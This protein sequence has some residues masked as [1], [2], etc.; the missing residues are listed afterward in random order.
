MSASPF[1][2]RRLG[3]EEVRRVLQ[4]ALELA[5]RDGGGGSLSEAE[6]A[7]RLTELG[8]PPEAVRLAMS[9][10]E[11]ERGD[12][13]GGVDGERYLAERELP[14]E[15]PPQRDADV[16]RALAGAMTEPGRVHTS[17]R[18]LTWKPLDDA[19]DLRVSVH[20]G[21]GRTRVRIEQS[22]RHRW[23]RPLGN[24]AVIAGF[25][26]LLAM[27]VAGWMRTVPLPF[28]LLLLMA[29]ATLATIA[30]GAWSTRLM[31]RSAQRRS[32]A[33]TT[34]LDRVVGATRTAISAGPRI[35]TPPSEEEE[36]EDSVAESPRRATIR[37]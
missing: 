20:S 5:E 32:A 12:D 10:R 33:L 14:G 21:E 7:D 13:G 1:R 3:P 9:G 24:A 35:A 22:F 8:L 4:R 15:V 11:A 31:Q 25:T 29:L 18:E 37:S 19:D 34:A 27:L 36:P 16:A 2:S 26:L 17:G 30:G 28:S 6:L 23:V